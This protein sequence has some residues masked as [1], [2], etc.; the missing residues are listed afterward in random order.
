MEEE[1]LLLG[2]VQ[3]TNGVALAVQVC[4]DGVQCFMELPLNIGELF[5]YFIG[6]PHKDL[7][8]SIKKKTEQNERGGGRETHRE[9]ISTKKT[10]KVY[11][12][13]NTS[14]KKLQFCVEPPTTFIVGSLSG[15]MYN[16]GS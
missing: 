15:V 10:Q 14:H 11:S 12:K 1:N 8:V 7:K 16:H 9:N 5:E 2:H 4:S 13:M 3:K 6:R